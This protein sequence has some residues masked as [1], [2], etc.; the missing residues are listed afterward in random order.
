M[1]GIELLKLLELELLE[2]LGLPSAA[3]LSCDDELVELGGG[4]M[5]PVLLLDKLRTDELVDLVLLLL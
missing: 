2:L 5:L 3:A 4:E 1:L